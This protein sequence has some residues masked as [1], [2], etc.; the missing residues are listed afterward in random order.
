MSR[1]KE[2]AKARSPE[3]ELPAG[4]RL[5]VTSNCNAAA[6]VGRGLCGKCYL[7]ARYLIRTKQ[8][9]WDELEKM[10]LCTPKRSKASLFLSE[11]IA[12]KTKLRR[13]E[14]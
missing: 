5:C 7:T 2:R 3:P 6:I 14:P 9:T 8:T 10:G 4:H 13:R 1:V 11:F 12:R